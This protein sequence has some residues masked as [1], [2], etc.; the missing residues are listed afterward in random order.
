MNK[1]NVFIWSLYDFA[2][3][4]VFITF[5]LYF[6]KWM[7]VNR[8]LSDWWYN[9]TF[10]L[11]SIGLVFFAPY[12]G[13]KADKHKNGRKYLIL[14]TL[15]CFIFYSLAIISAIL[16]T[17]IFISALMFGLGNFFYQLAFVFYNPLLNNISRPENQGKVSGIG[18]LANYL[19]QISGILV[20]LPFISGKITFPGIDPLVAALIPA[21][22]IFLILAVPLMLRK[23]IFNLPVSELSEKKLS[24]WNLLRSIILLPGVLLFFGAFFLF[25]D[26]ITTITNNVSIFTN[27][28]Y[29][30]TDSQI[31]LL[32]LVV[33][34]CAALGAFGWGWLSDRFGPKKTLLANLIFWVLIIPVLAWATSYGIFFVAA[35][36]A[37][38]CIGGSSSTSRRVLIELVPGTNLNYAFGIYAISERAATIVG[39][40]A[41]TMV[42]AVGGYRWAMFS[43][44]VFQII[45]VILLLKIMKKTS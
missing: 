44:V 34:T 41:W 35:L 5:L 4:F 19:G 8:G 28:V 26:A 10:I 31:S 14:S 13:S 17:N 33:I 27:Q 38:L 42:L 24:G 20:A 12:F 3:S 11:G 40:L 16:G 23:E 2:N 18:F 29:S 45:S 37:G 25:S 32:M 15:S 21:I 22:I 6:S 36:V 9:A 43:M 30:V 7:V 1:K 39:P